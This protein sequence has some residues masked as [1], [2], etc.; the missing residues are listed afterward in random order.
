VLGFE[1]LVVG[2]DLCVSADRQLVSVAKFGVLSA[3]DVS[4]FGPSF[5]TTPPARML[6]GFV[7]GGVVAE[8]WN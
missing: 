3:V 6:Y 8:L 1:G 7:S 4:G 2:G 5:A